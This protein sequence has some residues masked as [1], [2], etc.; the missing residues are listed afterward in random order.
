MDNELDKIIPLD[1]RLQSEYRAPSDMASPRPLGLL[2]AGCVFVG[3]IIVFCLILGM[4]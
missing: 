4:R 3:A 2:I 1:R